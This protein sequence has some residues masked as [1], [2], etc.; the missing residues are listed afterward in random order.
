MDRVPLH[1][2]LGVFADLLKRTLQYGGVGRTI[3]MLGVP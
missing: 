2:N 3:V 1:F